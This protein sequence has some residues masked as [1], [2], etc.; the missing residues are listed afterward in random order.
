MK[1]PIEIFMVFDLETTGLNTQKNLVC[2]IACC[3]FDSELNDLKE[4][5]SGIIK[6]YD[7]REIN[8]GALNANGITRAQLANGVDSKVVLTNFIK[9][10]KSFKKTAAKIILVGHNIKTFDIPFLEDFFKFHGEDLWK[11]VSVKTEID[12]MWW[13][14]MKWLESTNYKLG[15]CCE[16][17]GI[18]LM[19]AH[20]SLSDSRA[21]REL[22]KSF[23][24]SLRGEGNINVKG[25]EIQRTVFQF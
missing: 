17:V 12:T 21:N 2:E 10:I 18:D 7:D 23:L 16:N 3:P 24:R 1:S 13:A 22:A 19:D 9:Y 4:F 5:E 14:R 15:T 11:Y 8:E 20:R 6:P 25:K